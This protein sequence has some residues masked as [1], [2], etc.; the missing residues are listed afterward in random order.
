M[1]PERGAKGALT[2]EN[3]KTAAGYATEEAYGELAAGGEEVEGVASPRWWKVAARASW[4][5]YLPENTKRSFVF[6]H[7]LPNGGSRRTSLI[8]VKR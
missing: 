5:F 2:D 3:G 7:V 1:L 4:V 8:A 6:W